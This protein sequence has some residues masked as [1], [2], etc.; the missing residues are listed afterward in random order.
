MALKHSEEGI[1]GKISFGSIRNN[2]ALK[3]EVIAKS[4][5]LSFGSIRN[6]MALKLNAFTAV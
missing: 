1:F 6:N 2:M 3:H 5:L 4:N